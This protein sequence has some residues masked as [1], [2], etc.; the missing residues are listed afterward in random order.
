MT[1]G[2]SLILQ[3]LFLIQIFEAVVVH[4]LGRFVNSLSCL[5]E[6]IV[7]ATTLTQYVS[8]C[9]PQYL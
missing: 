4:L 8:M 5:S 6:E 3:M 7:G 9:L 1:K 2:L